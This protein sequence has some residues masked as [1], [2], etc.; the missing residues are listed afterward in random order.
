MTCFCRASES[1]SPPCPSPLMP[2]SA[3]FSVSSKLGMSPSCIFLTAAITFEPSP[4]SPSGKSHWLPP[5]RVDCPRH[6]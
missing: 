6:N 4:F 1:I 5:R 2:L 3:R